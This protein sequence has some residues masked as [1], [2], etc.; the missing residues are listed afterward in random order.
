MAFT[1]DA[2]LSGSVDASLKKY[3]PTLQHL[4]RVARL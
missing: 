1:F 4:K 2:L 3:Q